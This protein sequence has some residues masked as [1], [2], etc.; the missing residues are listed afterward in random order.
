VAPPEASISKL[1]WATWHRD[2]GELAMDV[3]GTEAT[4][5]DALPQLRSPL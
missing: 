2:L 4:V 3:L 5:A 1:F